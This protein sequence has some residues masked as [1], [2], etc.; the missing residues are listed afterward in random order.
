MF[1]ACSIQRRVGD[2]ID[3]GV[4]L[5]VKHA[6]ALVNCSQ[7]DGLSQVTFPRAGRTEKQS[8]FMFGDEAGSGK[9][10]NQAAIHLLIKIEVEVVEC[11]LGISEFSCFSSA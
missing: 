9:I 6:V 8:I 7:S 2:V 11:D 4:G 10:E 1:F 3:E 5:A